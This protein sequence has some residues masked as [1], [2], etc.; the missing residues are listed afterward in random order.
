MV[1]DFSTVDGYF[2]WQVWP[3]SDSVKIT[4]TADEAFQNSLKMAGKTGPYIMAV[5]L[6]QFKDLDDGSDMDAWVAPS[7]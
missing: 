1:K 7:D 5:S 6:W 3:M 4:C 2:N